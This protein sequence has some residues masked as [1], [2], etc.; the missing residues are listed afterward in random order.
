MTMTD[1]M[2]FFFLDIGDRC[3]PVISSSE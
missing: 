2:Y 1:F 3:L